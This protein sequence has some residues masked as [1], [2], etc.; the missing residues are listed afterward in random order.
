M[1]ELPARAPGLAPARTL[2]GTI[3]GDAVADLAEAT[4]FL[5]VDMDHF[6]RPLALIAANGFGRFDIPEPGKTGALEHPAHRR[7]RHARLPGDV[8]ACQ[9]LSAQRRDLVRYVGHSA[10]RARPRSRRPIRHAGGAIGKETLDPTGNHLRRY[11][12]CPRSMGFGTTA[13]NDVASHLL[14]T[15]W[16]QTG[17]LVDVHSVL[18]E[19]LKL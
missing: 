6:A 12:V 11:P 5:D 18:R 1:D 14:S 17:I 13:F 10:S 7:R 19:S 3:T 8:L 16:R 9:P 4:E 2:A 15:P